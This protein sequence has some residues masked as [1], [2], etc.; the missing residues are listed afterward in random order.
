MISH[1]YPFF[2]SGLR[3]DADLHLPDDGGSGAPYPVVIP[4]S[5]YQGL[6]VIHPE[7]FAR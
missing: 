2:S 6:K 4:A 7:R 5:G 1:P 3:L